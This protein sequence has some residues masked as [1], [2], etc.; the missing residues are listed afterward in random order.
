MDVTWTQRGITTKQIL[1][2][3]EDGHIMTLDKR[4]LDPRRPLEM[5]MEDMKEGVPQYFTMLNINPKLFINY[6][7]IVEKP[8]GIVTTPTHLEST[9]LVLCYGLDLFFTRVTGGKSYDRLELI[10][11]EE[12]I[13]VG[14]FLIFII[15]NIV[16]AISKRKQIK[17]PWK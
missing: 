3:L 16:N 17:T 1:A 4:L 7:N 10:F 2:T 5:K 6:H 11:N 9:S 14:I 8:K 13:I 15:T 12:W